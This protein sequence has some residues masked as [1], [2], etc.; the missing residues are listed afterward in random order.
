VLKLA[1]FLRIPFLFFLLEIAA[2]ATEPPPFSSGIPDPASLDHPYLLFNRSDLPLLRRRTET[3][4]HSFIWERMTARPVSKTDAVTNAFVYAVTGD[5]RRGAAAQAELARLC[6]M[7]SWGAKAK[8]EVSEKCRPAGLIYDLIY[9]RLT[10]A[11]RRAYADRIAEAGIERLY[12][13]TFDAWWSARRQH[14]YSPVFNSAYGLAALAILK[15][16]PDAARWVER[17]AE[18]V[19]LFL[20]SQ[21]PAGGFGEGVNYWCMTMRS[22]FPFLDVLRRLAGVDLYREP[23]LAEATGLFVLYSLSPDGRSTLNFNDAGINRAYD[24]HVLVQMASVGNWPEIALVV[25]RD[26][27]DTTA[28]DEGARP[29]FRL[30]DPYS[31]LWYDPG[32]E[33]APLAALPRSRFFPGIGWAVMRSGWEGDAVQIGIASLPKFFGNHDHG[34][35]GSFILN[36]FGE[37]LII[38]GG[39][40]VSYADPLMA[41]WYRGSA[42]H[43]VLLVDGAGQTHGN[44]LSAPGR[45]SRFVS[46]DDLDYVMTENAGPYE[47]RVTRWD[48]HVVYGVPGVVV[49]FDQVVLPRPG[50]ASFRFHSPGDREIRLTEAGAIF[51]GDNG[52][53][54]PS[55]TGGRRRLRAL[56]GAG[57]A[58]TA[59]WKTGNPRPE[60]TGW[61]SAEEG[62]T[63]LVLRSFGDGDPRRVVHGGYQDYRYPAT[64]LEQSYDGVEAANIVTVL[65]PRS[66]RMKAAGELPRVAGLSRGGSTA[67]TIAQRERRYLVAA[68]QAA[69][70]NAETGEARV[71]AGPLSAAG[72]L[73]MAVVTAEGEPVAG[74][75]VNGTT[76]RFGDAMVVEVDRPAWATVALDGRAM[77]IVLDVPSPSG[78]DLRVR[79]SEAPTEVTV[80][81]V[82]AFASFSPER[83]RA[84]FHVEP[85]RSEVVLTR[86]TER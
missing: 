37:R 22:L 52:A 82:P 59:W 28:A 26:L 1:R 67:V 84:E 73:A 43:N 20:R 25:A 12:R 27:A 72:D 45:A 17:A 54:V 4:P 15:E 36:A 56:H 66:A 24:A 29:R 78:A 62:T 53:G 7:P 71:T 49:L 81:G 34:D 69:G 2:S 61:T 86:G 8:L 5:E 83:N 79:L 46:T 47:G 39:K 63:D 14:N 44:A 21:D 80:D 10:P 65:V 19:R 11:E 76:W 6:A 18:R 38:D 85:G 58:D 35:R 9:D 75:L 41:T 51:P 68:R 70:G 13:G 23:W 48:R 57:Y 16:R 33:T 55:L 42:S 30:G 77:R 64:Y 40:S 50:T 74:L 32:V 60:P 31:F 3:L